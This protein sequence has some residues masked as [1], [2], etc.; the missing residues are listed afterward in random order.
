MNWTLIIALIAL[1]I[2][3][4]Y[5]LRKK[6]IS[7]WKIP[8][9]A[10]PKRWHSILVQH[11]PFYNALDE[12]GK[13]Y[14]EYEIQEFLLNCRITGIK[15][16]VKDLD[17][18]LIAASAVIPIFEFRDWKYTNLK[19]VL[20]YPSS[21]TEKFE[22]E[23]KDRSI[24]GM[25]GNGYMEGMMILSK[26]SLRHGFQNETDKKNTAIH[27]FV[28]LVDKA[29]GEIDGIP[30]LLLEKQYA[31]PW[32]DMINKKMDEIYAQQSDINPYGGTNKAEFFSVVSEYFFE[33]PKLLERKHPELY[34]LM[35]Q[36]FKADMS[37]LDLKT[38]R[39]G[40]NDACPCG[41][42]KKFKHCCGAGHYG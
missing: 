8:T 14:F 39:I 34:H 7:N 16:T 35:E 23:G 3:L 40:R 37:D 32:M 26:T 21:F 10:F 4:V 11:V 20:L 33:R 28:H 42:G 24:L 17:R 38:K 9:T 6:S 31:I 19:E 5:F 30:K 18:V 27:E 29:D 22:T 13:K 12:E 15:T 41:S 36:I 1:F 25:V 2:F